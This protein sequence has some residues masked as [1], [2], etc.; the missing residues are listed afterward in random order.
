MH[1]LF[2]STLFVSFTQL[3]GSSQVVLVVKNPP[4]S[5]RDVRGTGLIPGLG[6]STRRGNGN[7]PQYSC[8]E[9]SMSRGAWWAT[10]LGAAK[11]QTQLR[12]W[13]HP[14][15]YTEFLFIHVVFSL[16]RCFKKNKKV[17]P[18]SAFSPF[19]DLRGKD[20]LGF[21]IY[22]ALSYLFQSIYP[23]ART[24]VKVKVLLA[25]SFLTLCVPMD[26]SLPGSSVHGILQARILEWVA[27]P[28]SRGS[29]WPRDRTC[30]CCI[31]RWV[32]Y[33]W[34]TREAPC[35]IL[36]S[37]LKTLDPQSRYEPKLRRWMPAPS[38]SSSVT[39]GKIFHLPTFYFTHL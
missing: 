9:N 24:Y 2:C 15:W 1:T 27:F 22:N 38:L 26:C 30:V 8:L 3:D 4:A 5:P 37:Y 19:P 18:I 6:R 17:C 23:C 21:G 32:L 39:L 28:F 20:R 34:A 11:S 25:Q 33:H 12:D 14:G 35:R 16:F 13:A 10:V 31:E 29:S 7:P 36:N